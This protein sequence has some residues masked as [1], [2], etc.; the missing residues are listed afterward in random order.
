M[1]VMLQKRAGQGSGTHCQDCAE[2]TGRVQVLSGPT[3]PAGLCE[4]GPVD[5]HVRTRPAGQGA[6]LQIWLLE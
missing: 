4:L 5:C 6:S 1:C 3:G 2:R